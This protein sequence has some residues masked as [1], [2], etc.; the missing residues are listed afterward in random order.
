MIEAAH[1]PGATYRVQLNR[2]FTFRDARR[3]V[4]YL[5]DLGITDLYTSPFLRAA[6]E[7]THGYDVTDHNALNPAIGTEDSLTALA[8]ELRE[9]QMTMLLDIVPNHMGVGNSANTW[10]NDVLENGPASVYAPYFDI[11]WR[12]LKAELHNKVQLPILGDQYGRVLEHGELKLH[13][14]PDEGFFFLQYWERILPI[15]P[16]TYALI[17]DGPCRRLAARLPSDDDNLLELQSILTAI[18]YLPDRDA[19]DPRLVAQRNREKEVIKRR[20]SSLVM[21]A[22][23]VGVEIETEVAALNGQPGDPHSFDALDA[24]LQEQVYRLSFWRVAAEEINYRRFFDVNE[25]AA[26]RIENPRVFRD[27]HRLIFRLL[28]QKKAAGLRVDHP[29]GLWDPAQYF[30]RLR[31]WRAVVEAE[32]REEDQ[33]ILDAVVDGM[34]VDGMPLPPEPLYVVVEKILASD[35]TLPDDWPVH[36][37]TGYEFMNV[38]GSLFVDGASRRRFDELYE[39]FINQRIDFQMLA[40]ESKRN[41]MTLSLAS[42]VNVL[43]SYLNQIS[44]RNRRSRDF[45]LHALRRAV[46]EVI[47][48]FPVYRTYI[49][50]QPIAERDRAHI[51]VAI[52]WARR[53][54]PAVE[55]TIFQ[56]LHDTLL[57]QAADE[58][59]VEGRERL[60]QF[61]MKF[62]Q[63]TG[64]V[65]AKAVEDTA[66]YI[67]NRLV[68]LN[69]VGGEPDAFGV[70]VTAFHRLNA[71]RLQNWPHTLV[72]TSTHDTKRSEDVRARISVL[73]EFPREWSQAIARWARSNR[74]KKRPANGT[75]SPSRNDEYLLYQIL[76]G[77]W[78]LGPLGGE[79]RSVFV[80]RIQEYM[81]KAT[82]EAKVHTSWINPNEAYDEAVREFVGAILDPKQSVVFLEDFARFRPLVVRAGAVNS[83]SQTLLKLTVP[84]V[85]DTYQGN[86]IWDFSLV[87]PD[88]RRPVDYG[89][90]GRMLRSLMR[91][92]ERAGVA[93]GD[94]QPQDRNSVEHS[95]PD[96]G[97]EPGQAASDRPPDSAV[98]RP[99]GKLVTSLVEEWQDGRIKLY[100][101]WRTLRFRREHAD[102]FKRG[103]YH[104]I[105]AT[106]RLADHVCAFAR[107]LARAAGGERILVAVPRLTGR[108]LAD[109]A[110]SNDEDVGIPPLGPLAFRTGVWEGTDLLLPDK[111]GIRYRDLFTGA[112]VETAAPP[113]RAPDGVR[114]ALPLAR[115]FASFPVTLL[116]RETP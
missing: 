24:L 90:R 66:F 54:N 57:L 59:D 102:L 70:A 3:I 8:S 25:L 87:D 107:E 115:L 93:D 108:L 20:L 34:P 36:G 113:D 114:S 15:A 4:P 51:E 62:Q 56:F 44:E 40:Y 109:V 49:T 30:H 99:L 65:T 26:I 63:T 16:R 7:S 95:G 21:V 79:S 52:A 104:P 48:C 10:W 37:T 74:G 67:Y 55:P 5:A 72:A 22:P 64:P 105:G 81:A 35:E 6:P 53:R 91:A 17:L 27:T 60:L 92:V 12:P 42:E 94:G 28:R 111:P 101:T 82:K 69:E 80:E 32:R 110:A 23:E 71:E 47:A 83:L 39:R 98:S 31:R 96:D 43:T 68:S 41:V 9:Q 18:S 38:V 77:A 103:A 112:L 106:G 50:G 78:P 19:T 84:G 100:L 1:V 13:F 73:S 89:I 11:D 33:A 58:D 86:E 116:H 29:D 76:L 97:A 45:T 61:V 2:G 88:N 85:P 75:P 14:V 46:R